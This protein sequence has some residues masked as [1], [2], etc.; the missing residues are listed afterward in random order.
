MDVSGIHGIT[1]PVPERRLEENRK[2]TATPASKESDKVEISEEGRRA[3]DV[4]RYVSLS[5]RLPLVRP[6]RVAAAKSNL[7]RGVLNDPEA[8]RKTAER[9][10]EDLLS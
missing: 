7:R 1:G 3:A 9:I 2:P 6:D 10:L 5:K 8:I 4:A